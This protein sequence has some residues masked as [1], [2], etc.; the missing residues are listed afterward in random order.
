M[1]LT[2]DELNALL[3]PSEGVLRVTA[4]QLGAGPVADLLTDWLTDGVLSLASAHATADSGAGT[5]TVTG[6][7]TAGTFL[8]IGQATLTSGVFTLAGDGSLAARLAIAVGD[9]DWG[10]SAS[11]PVLARSVCDSLS[12]ADPV[13]TL[14]SADTQPLPAD[15]RTEFGFPAD[16]PGAGHL[17][18]GLSFTALVS[19]A[20]SLASK[21]TGLVATPLDLAG[22]IRVYSPPAASGSGSASTP[23]GYPEFLLAPATGTASHAVV[24]DGQQ[25]TVTAQLACLL[26]ATTGTGDGGGTAAPVTVNAVLALP[27]AW[28]GTGGLP[29][30]TLRGVVTGDAT[31]TLVLDTGAA[32]LTPIG[33]DEMP[34]LLAGTDVS[35]LLAPGHDFPLFQELV[36]H[37][38]SLTLGLGPL[39]LREIAAL[40]VLAAA[41]GAPDPVW[42]IL[43]GLISLHQLA[44]DVEVAR[45][46]DGA[47]HPTAAV[48]GSATIGQGPTIILTAVVSLPGLAVTAQLDASAPA[49]LTAL[50]KDQFGI[51]LPLPTIT[52][53]DVTVS[54]DVAA[55]TWT[56]DTQ[57]R[58]TWTLL[59]TPPDG[60]A[61]QDIALH[62]AGAPGT[63]TTGS[64]NA[65]LEVGGASLAADADYS[66]AD[67][68]S[69]HAAL[70]MGSQADLAAVLTALLSA[71]GLSVT[72]SLPSVTLTTLSV[73]Y[74]ESKNELS[75][76][77]AFGDT[78]VTLLQQLGQDLGL[79]GVPAIGLS[80]IDGSLT[81]T[82]SGTAITLHLTATDWSI[83]LGPA[84]LTVSG[85]ALDVTHTPAAVATTG[86]GGTPPAPA[87]AP[88]STTA[89]ITGTLAL[90][91]ASATVTATLPGAL[92]ITG[93]FPAVGLAQLVGTLSGNTLTLPAALAVTLPASTVQLT[94]NAGVFQL[95]W[96]TATS[97]LGEIAL[98]AQRLP[99]A[100]WGV[101]AG[102]A[103]PAN[104]KLSSLS[105]A[106]SSLDGLTF[107]SAA[108]VLASFADPTFAFTDLT[109]PAL[110]GG[111]VEGLT[112][113]CALAL[114][115]ALAGAGSMLGRPSVDVTAVIGPDP[116]SI[117]L[118][119][120]LAGT[121]AIPPTTNL[122]LGDLA[123]SITPDPLGVSL[124]GA[125]T[126]PVGSQTLMAT[127]RFSVTETA[128]D[129]ALDVTGSALS[130]AAPMG[131]RGVVLDEIG[132][133]AG[134]TFEPPGLNLGL[135]GAFH[136][137]NQPASDRFAFA[138]TVEGEAVTPTLLSGHLDQLDLPT[139]F[140][141]CMLPTA[142]LPSVLNQISFSDLTLYW[143]DTEQ[144]LP[145][146]STAQPG[147]GLSGSMLAFG[148]NAMVKLLMDFG[149]GVHGEAS[150]DPVNL[151]GG[152]FTLTGTGTTGGPHVL[153]DT[154]ASPYLSV[155][156]NA[157][158]LDIIG[159][160]VQGTL[161]SSGLT[162]SLANHLGVL[163]TALAITASPTGASLASSV[164][165]DLDVMA[166]PLDIPGSGLTLGSVHVQAGFSG[167]ITINISTAGF[168]A[169][170][171]GGFI[172]Q[173]QHWQLATVTVT[174]TPADVA[175]IAEAVAQAVQAQAQTLFGEL[176]ADS[177][178]YFGLVAGGLVSGASDAST[179]AMSVYHL[180]AD[181]TTTL[182][183][184]LN[185][186]TSSTMHTDVAS[187]HVD[188]APH[189][190][191]ASQHVDTPA[192]HADT[193]GAHTDLVPRH[194]DVPGTHVD[195][196]NHVD[197]PGGPHTDFSVFGRHADTQL[198]PH[199]DT[200]PHGDQ[201]LTPHGDTS[202]P[203]SDFAPHID[204]TAIPHVDT[205]TPHVDEAPHTDEAPHVDDSAHIDT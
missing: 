136:L 134:I 194:V 93:S 171:D 188:I 119:A 13:F 141:A 49:D 147:F 189:T 38:V 70:A 167:S 35:G 111:V 6:T 64:L 108:L 139:L 126:I 71:A 185:L 33:T 144:P 34:A 114:S 148:W 90:A 105:S 98:Q 50:V 43:G 18:P 27:T 75:V 109:L 124:S 10:L 46:S 146:G 28:T 196:T 53:A 128:A 157:K 104:W 131:F 149:S 204:Q 154:T 40:L 83:P 41:T 170:I 74:Q 101:A 97:P 68:W 110:S 103:L 62:L 195:T 143:C 84:T 123:L 1:P 120:A 76:D 4:A 96:H 66:T 158:L 201:T 127:G 100:G 205:S 81:E 80:A 191:A 184:N 129:F 138:F 30:I 61:L 39:S 16:D 48:N 44:F 77:A 88:A 173:G 153:V 19:P 190:D 202:T 142:V 60:V 23:A 69:V 56:F 51:A 115:G 182:F 165:F 58:E 203:H 11:F 156:L 22:P 55:A 29:P 192:N 25:F 186:T 162:F 36:L 45:G 17:L 54:G 102:F 21:I 113:G 150:C 117:K 107:T 187:P 177:N 118:S 159:E 152:A 94:E 181:D 99:Q 63:P 112:F 161:S 59:G 174:E 37:R 65:D 89:A 122:L 24:V 180:T 179:L 176:L 121:V 86:T 95:A 160:N 178:R 26:T 92:T 78:D 137:V 151:V 199:G 198:P 82:A 42:S 15:V 9:A 163:D 132:V 14:D 140:G 12:Y 183:R 57:V 5:V 125:L 155:S 52:S 73:G 172:W 166:G 175:H 20:S 145:D 116:A 197:T 31:D 7:V 164:N 135:A 47:L 85:V 8:G 130:L 168:H 169:T 72:A 67:G 2:F 91:G 133:V 79:P 3:T 193:P 106:L 87:P 32:P 200:S